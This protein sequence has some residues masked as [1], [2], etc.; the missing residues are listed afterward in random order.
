MTGIQIAPSGFEAGFLC[1]A[2]TEADVDAFV[3]AVDAPAAQF[4]VATAQELQTA[5]STAAANGEDDTIFLAA[6]IYRPHLPFY[7][8]RKYFDLYPL[9]RIQPPPI[10][11]TTP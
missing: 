11:L 7:A 10:T 2:H 3:A 4:H 5:L 6:G 8:P 9:D 1:A